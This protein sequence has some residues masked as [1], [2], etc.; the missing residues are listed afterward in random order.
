MGMSRRAKSGG[1]GVDSS[2]NICKKLKIVA[3]VLWKHVSI[4]NLQRVKKNFTPA[5]ICSVRNRQLRNCDS[6][7]SH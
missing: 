3:V 2:G 6:L 5:Y 4:F 7:A 1:Q